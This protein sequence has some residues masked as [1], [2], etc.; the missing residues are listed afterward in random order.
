MTTFGQSRAAG[1]RRRSGRA[2]TCPASSSPARSARASP[3]LQEARHPGQ[4]RAR[5]TAPATTRAILARHIAGDALRGRDRAP[6]R[7]ARTTSLVPAARGDPRARAVAPEGLPR[8]GR[9]RSTRRRRRAT[10]GSCRSPTSLDG[11]RGRRCP[12]DDGRG[13]RDGVHLPGRC[14][15][16]GRDDLRGHAAGLDPLLHFA[17]RST[18]PR[19]PRPSTA[20]PGSRRSPAGCRADGVGWFDTRR[21]SRIRLHP[22]R[23]AVDGYPGM[24]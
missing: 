23:L 21:A 11:L 1:R 7:R 20:S 9:S 18:S 14:T 16:A 24:G 8:A 13:G 22:Y 19:W 6:G 12:G 3:G 4:L 5:S 10:R 17:R 2:P 15:C